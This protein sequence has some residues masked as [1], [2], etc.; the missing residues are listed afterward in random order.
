MQNTREADELEFLEVRA[1]RG[2]SLGAGHS[3]QQ[4]WGFWGPNRR[5]LWQ[6]TYRPD[7][8]SVTVAARVVSYGEPAVVRVRC[9]F[10]SEK[11]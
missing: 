8:I 5:D 9:G 7:S 11:K 4:P 6:V 3:L 2:V 1:G 10:E